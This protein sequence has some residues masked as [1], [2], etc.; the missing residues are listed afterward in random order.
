MD[1]NGNPTHEPCD[2]AGYMDLAPDDRGE[3]IRRE[4]CLTLEQMGIFPE[5]SHHEEGP[6]QNEIVY[7]PSDPLAASDNAMTFQTVVRTIAYR[8]GLHADFGPK[9]LE[10]HPGNGFHIN[11]SVKSKDSQ[12][13]TCTVVAG[14]LD[15]I[16]DI[17]LFLNPLRES[18]LRLGSFKAP[19]Y[20]SWSRANRSVLVRIPAVANNYKRAELRSPDP[21]ANPYIA[22]TLLLY[23]GLY[24]IASDLELSAAT[25]INFYET[26][27]DLPAGI[28]VLPSSLEEARSLALRS[29]FV[30][31]I[32]PERI[33]KSYTSR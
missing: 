14:I 6:G 8:N 16:Q 5:R 4:I 3:N 2:N 29:T 17:T 21:A 23:A 10:K 25:D 12:D 33:I 7:R 9:P 20:I 27:S 32:L 18:Y 13:L 11:I 15:K 22:L 28:K 24:G 1:K 26:V 19:R 31:E 30:K